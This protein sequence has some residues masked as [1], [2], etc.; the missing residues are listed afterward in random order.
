MINM[1]EQLSLESGIITPAHEKAVLE[2][3]RRGFRDSTSVSSLSGVGPIAEFE[4]AFADACGARFALA[5]SSCTAALHTALLAAGVG[6]G[7][8]VIVSPYSWGQS[9]S[10]VLF[11]GATAVFADIDDTLTL[12]PLSVK[13]RISNRTKA[14]LPVHLFGNPADMDSLCDL[15]KD[16]E[17]HIISDAAQAL[18]AFS[19][20]RKIGGLG[21]MTCFSLG[22]GKAVFGGEGG[23]LATDDRAHYEKAVAISQHPLRVFRDVIGKPD[24]AGSELNRNYRIHPLAASL[25]LAD[26]ELSPKRIAHRKRILG[27]VHE[28]AKTI[29]D[30]EAVCCRREDISAAY[31][32][33]LTYEFRECNGRSRESFIESMHPSGVSINSGPVRMPIHLRPAFQKH[34]DKVWPQAYSHPSHEKGSCPVAEQRCR[35]EELLLFSANT[36]DRMELP[37]ALKLIN[38]F[39]DNCHSLTKSVGCTLTFS[40]S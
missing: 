2:V 3:L 33:P 39:K 17:I 7:D 16:R 37:D 15:A 9:V 32:V 34:G 13:S 21:H 40:S 25:A 36:L 38:I 19:K 14:I 28:T 18:G 11:T 35:N 10:P 8:E 24:I 30:I 6:P 12:D 5:L 31:G 1:E 22:R 26:L 23:V 20:G 4:S 27:A 29:P